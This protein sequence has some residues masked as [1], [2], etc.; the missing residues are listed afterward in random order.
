MTAI[1]SAEA[2]RVVNRL[3]RAQGQ[4]TA[5]VTMLEE[6]RDCRDIVTQL[7]AASSA[8][9]RAGSG[10]LSPHVQSAFMTMAFARVSSSGAD[11]RR[12]GYLRDVD[13]VTMNRERLLSDARTVARRRMHE[14]YHPPEPRSAVPVLGP[15]LMAVLSLGVHL[16]RRAGRISDH[17]AL[18]GRKLAW[19]LSGGGLPHRTTVTEQYLL[20]L[21][22]VDYWLK[23]GASPS[24]T[25]RSLIT[26]ARKGGA[27]DVAVGEVA[28]DER[29]AKRAEVLASR[30]AEQRGKA[31]ATETQPVPEEP[32]ADTAEGDEANP[33]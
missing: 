7:S 18:I 5:V 21:E 15:D 6:G 29:Q 23:E 11:A 27:E 17:D 26:K 28:P 8:I 33:T 16:A 25:V 10:D 24:D 1:P 9:D 14:G 32:A 12:L 19:I 3:R 31:K 13:G 2:R 20:D 22:R 30:A 4:L